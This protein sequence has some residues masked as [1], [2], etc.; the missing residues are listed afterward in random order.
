VH[1]P[2]GLSQQLEGLDGAFPDPRR[3]I[4]PPDHRDQI[5]DVAV[6]VGIV[7]VMMLVVVVVMSG[8]VRRLGL[9]QGL[10][11][12]TDRDLGASDAAPL[13]VFDAN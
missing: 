9:I 7:V 12:E 3:E 11:R 4:S 8:A 5:A 2:L 13:D 1:S 6:C 10:A